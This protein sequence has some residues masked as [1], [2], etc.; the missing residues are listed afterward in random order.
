MKSTVDELSW[1]ERLY[2]ANIAGKV[3]GGFG[4]LSDWLK[5]SPPAT[6]SSGVSVRGEGDEGS[7]STAS[8]NNR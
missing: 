3:A 5:R 7:S 8:G 6:G 4:A 1:V 2:P